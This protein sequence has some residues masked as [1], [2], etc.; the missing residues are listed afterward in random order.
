[1]S[2]IKQCL[3]KTFGYD[4]FRQ[5]QE[6]IINCIL[7]KQDVL[8]LM[9]TGAGKSLCFQ[10]PAILSNGVTVVISPL[11]SLIYDQVTALR[12]MGICT[13]Y[14]NSTTPSGEK[15]ELLEAIDNV[16]TDDMP[17]CRCKLLYTTPE[18]V[19]SNSDFQMQLDELY[20]NGLLE[21]FVI[22]E[23]H[24][25]S[26]WGH[27]FRNSYLDL[28][29]IKEYY[30]AIPIWTFTAT[31]TKKVQIDIVSQ[32]KLSEYKIF[33]N[34]FIRKNLS[35]QIYERSGDVNLKVATLINTTYR[36]KT[37]I[38]YCL[39]RADCEDLASYLQTK[40]IAAKHYHAQIPAAQKESTQKE[41]LSG[42]IKVI[43]ATIAFALGINKP[44]V[45][46]V[47]HT[48]MPSSVESYYQE[49][50]RAGRD[51]G[52][53]DC[54]LFYSYQDKIVLEKLAG[55]STTTGVSSG[56]APTSAKARIGTMYN[57]CQNRC[58]CIKMQ[59]CHYLGEF[60]DYQCGSDENK[61]RNCNEPTKYQDVDFTDVAQDLINT[62]KNSRDID[63]SKLAMTVSAKYSTYTTGDISR[64]LHKL[65]VMGNLKT[66]VFKT[67]SGIIE[68]VK[69]GNPL[70]AECSISL[71]HVASARASVMRTVVKPVSFPRQTISMFDDDSV[72]KLM[73]SFGKK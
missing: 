32:L 33:R 13:Y 72:K 4:E 36:D 12:E 22:D 53:S 66:S 25:V 54:I 64:I 55:R 62:V 37:G 58:D 68:G 67:G 20:E 9:P 51:L 27:D 35:Y 8:V 2:D 5:G 43:V 26:N 44:D 70:G 61:C 30:S 65:L 47:I 63:K 19:T 38:V 31:A 16:G 69:I 50:G 56:N 1:M 24:C 60:I 3:K 40:G 39:R 45:R 59:M 73:K 49:T 42:K 21:G 15:F 18:T 11:I 23:A 41:W 52:N 71:K 34:S 29:V 28:N 17:V 48:A 57:M 7:N 46:Y 6:E 10:L 14:L